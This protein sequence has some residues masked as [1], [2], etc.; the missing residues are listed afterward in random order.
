MCQLVSEPFHIRS[1]KLPEKGQNEM[2]KEQMKKTK[3]ILT[4]QH[5]SDEDPQLL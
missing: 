3:T 1:P 5:N 2:K 4:F